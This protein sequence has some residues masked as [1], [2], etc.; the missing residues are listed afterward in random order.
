M[1]G[2]NANH[3]NPPSTRGATSRAD[4]YDPFARGRFPVGVRTIQALDTARNR[5]FPCEIWYPTAAQHAGH[6]DILRES[7][8]GSKTMGS[9]SCR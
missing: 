6:A 3:T 5:L 1:T 8:D 4:E 2:G 7:L 9:P